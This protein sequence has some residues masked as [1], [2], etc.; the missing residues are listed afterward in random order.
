MNTKDPELIYIKDV[1]RYKYIKQSDSVE[2]LPG[3]LYKCLC[4]TWEGKARRNPNQY[5]PISPEDDLYIEAT[6]P[7]YGKKYIGYIYIAETS[8]NE[9]W[10]ARDEDVW[11]RN[12]FYLDK[13]DDKRAKDIIKAKYHPP[14]EKQGTTINYNDLAE[15]EEPYDRT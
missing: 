13:R 7:L 3:K 10:M 6:N 4:S 11:L 9:T 12:V 2:I 1:V 5:Y 14:I 15:E 8:N